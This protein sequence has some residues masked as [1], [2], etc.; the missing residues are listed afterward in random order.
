MFPVCYKGKLWQ[1]E[2]C[3]DVFLAL[4]NH[5]HNSDLEVVVY[6]FGDDWLFPDGK[7]L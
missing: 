7:I 2:D 1:E 3:D 6:K 5:P 4:Y